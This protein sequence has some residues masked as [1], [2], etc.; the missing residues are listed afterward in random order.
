MSER[1]VFAHTVEGLF[2]RG[3]SG[4]LSPGTYRVSWG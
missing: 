1:L 2:E 4:R 3:V